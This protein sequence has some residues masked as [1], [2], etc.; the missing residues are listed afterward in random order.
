MFQSQ[1]FYLVMQA[2]KI[3]YSQE[4]EEVALFLASGQL[5]FKEKQED[6]YTN[7]V[8]RKEFERFCNSIY[9]Y[10]L[11]KVLLFLLNC[12]NWIPMIRSKQGGPLVC[13]SNSS[14]VFPALLALVYL[15]LFS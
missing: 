6:F 10:N 5:Q 9:Y 2:Q 12:L 8:R 11:Y 14:P 3:F 7:T 15:N 1:I 4:P 13:S